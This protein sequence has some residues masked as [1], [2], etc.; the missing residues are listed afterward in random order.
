ML[1]ES[2]FFDEIVFKI[3]IPVLFFLFSLVGRLGFASQSQ[4]I[5]FFADVCTVAVVILVA[6]EN[7]CLER[8]QALVVG[9]I[10][11]V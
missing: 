4:T 9:F 1:I 8:A 3:G 2:K 7:E 11:V 5:V 10:Q 6:S